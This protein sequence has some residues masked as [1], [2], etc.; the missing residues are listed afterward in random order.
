MYPGGLI[1]GDG[2]II[3]WLLEMKIRALRPL[4]GLSFLQRV[5]GGVTV[6][7]ASEAR[8]A[9]QAQSVQ[10]SSSLLGSVVL[11]SHN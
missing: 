5:R 10:P 7:Q 8:Q 4:A 11:E 2:V 3:L 6:L 9:W 1:T